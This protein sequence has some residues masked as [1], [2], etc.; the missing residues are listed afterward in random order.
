MQMP[1]EDGGQPSL[2]EE[3]PD[4]IKVSIQAAQ[5]TLPALQF[6]GHLLSEV[7]A[8]EDCHLELFARD[9]AGNLISEWHIGVEIYMSGNQLS[10]MIERLQA[11]DYPILWQGQYPVWMDGETGVKVD[12]PPEGELFERLARRLMKKLRMAA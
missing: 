9:E 5:L 6:S 3:L 1:L 7:A 11:P 10:L 4:L 2:S 12:S 8:I